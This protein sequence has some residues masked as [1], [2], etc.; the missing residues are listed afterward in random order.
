[1]KR[2]FITQSNPKLNLL[3]ASAFG[4][5]IEV[6]PASSNII[7]NAGNTVEK[8]KQ[9]LA[10]FDDGDYLLPVGA[11]AIMLVCGSV[12]AKNNSGRY[13]VLTWD[14]QESMY[15]SIDIDLLA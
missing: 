14:R 13:K 6:L 4:E 5:L 2:V 1:M 8:I 12:A 9:E 7:Y 11:P 10:D 3:A 15:Y